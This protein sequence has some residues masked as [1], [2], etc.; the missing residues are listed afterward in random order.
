MRLFTLVQNWRMITRA[1]KLQEKSA[2]AQIGETDALIK[3]D[4]DPEEVRRT[5]E[6]LTGV[7]P[8]RSAMDT[9]GQ[10]LKSKP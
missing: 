10:M 8:A 1:S 7:Q 3:R 6:I 2:L 5:A 4:I 9:F